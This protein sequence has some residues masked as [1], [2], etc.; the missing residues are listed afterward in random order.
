MSL[1]SP[2]FM[3]NYLQVIN[4]EMATSL[5][6]F[7]EEKGSLPCGSQLVLPASP[8]VG[9]SIYSGSCQVLSDCAS[10]WP[11]KSCP[12]TA[13]TGSTGSSFHGESVHRS[14]FPSDTQEGVPDQ[15]GIPRG[16]WDGCPKKKLSWPS[17]PLST[18]EPRDQHCGDKS[19][20]ICGPGERISMWN[21]CARCKTKLISDCNKE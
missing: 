20:G 21:S 18:S 2:N 19:P 14:C 5:L 13:W 3:G 4:F 7:V 15:S 1:P 6:G 9:L 12:G 17:F 11:P 8:S 10:P 16:L